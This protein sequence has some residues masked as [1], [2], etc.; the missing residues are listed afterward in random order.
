MRINQRGIIEEHLIDVGGCRLFYTLYRGSKETIVLE[1]GGGADSSCWGSFPVDLVKETG[2]TV[3]SY[4]RAGFGKSDLPEHP[5]DMVEETC[6]FMNGMH[7]LG[8]GEDLILVGHSYGGWLIRLTVS[9]YPSAV[10]GLVFV[11]PFSTE[12]V[13]LLGVDYLDHHPSCRKDLPFA[14]L[15]PEELT[16]NQRGGIRM[17]KEGL[18]PKVRIMRDLKIPA[19]IPTRI[20][21]AGEPWWLSPEEDQAWR[22]AHEQIAAKIPSAELMIAEGCDHSIPEKQPEIIIMAIR[23]VMMPRSIN[24]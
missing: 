2:A 21:T 13:D 19:N 20:I 15:D 1:A 4:D 7:Q 9:L 12:F 14:H 22:K 10:R 3:V 8:L 18:G 16:K 23:E 5:Y 24:D 11:D 6:W 17:A